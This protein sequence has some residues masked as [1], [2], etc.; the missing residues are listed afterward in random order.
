MQFYT[1]INKIPVKNWDEIQKSFRA[2]NPDLTPLI[3]KGKYKEKHRPKLYTAYLNLL[4]QLPKLSIELN[5]LFSLFELEYYKYLNFQVKNKFRKL[6]NLKEIELTTFPIDKAFNN[7]ITE[8]EK[9]YTEFEFTV[10][11]ISET[12]EKDYKEIF[13]NEIPKEFNAKMNFILVEDFQNDISKLDIEFQINLY[14]G[15]EKFI[16][17]EKLKLTEIKKSIS[18]HHFRLFSKTLKEPDKWQAIRH[19]M[20]NPKN[21]NFRAKKDSSIFTDILNLGK[22]YNQSIDMEKITVGQMFEAF[23][24]IEEKNR[25]L[26]KQNKPQSA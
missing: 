6:D 15:Y 16:K 12:F 10:F 18:D 24:D 4:Y 2:G 26:K 20:F 5:K 19:D 23:K 14:A 8:L 3:L 21:L 11:K 7:Y 1:D 25:D 9:N 17:P 22:Y 13:K